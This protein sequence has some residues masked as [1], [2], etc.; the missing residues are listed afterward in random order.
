MTN[1]LL[2]HLITATMSP[3]KAPDPVWKAVYR[4][5][6]IDSLQDVDISTLEDI[7]YEALETLWKKTFWNEELQ[8]YNI[9]FDP[10]PSI[11]S[12]RPCYSE[13]FYGI[14]SLQAT[15]YKGTQTLFLIQNR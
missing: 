10:S 6:Y 3:K 12:F 11:Y 4:Q 14:C 1:K 7:S 5:F 2:R 13:I 8:K 9:G 15:I